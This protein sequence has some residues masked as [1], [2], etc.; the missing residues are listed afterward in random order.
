MRRGLRIGVALWV[1]WLAGTAAAAETPSSGGPDPNGVVARVNQVE[2]TYGEFKSRLESFERERGPIPRERYGD[3]LRGMIQEEVLLQAAVADGLD[4]EAATRQ[5]LEQARRQVL[6]EELIRRKVLAQVTVT[7]E[8]AR[9]MYEDN[10]PLF[11]TET[12]ATSHILVKTQAEAEAVLQEL[13][14]GKEFA[15]LAQTRSQDTGS[16]EKGGDLGPLRRGQTVPEFE[17]EAFRLKE[18]ELSAVLKTEYGYHVL[19]GGAHATVVQPFDEVKDRIRQTLLQEKQRK[20]FTALLAELEK[21]AAAE[22]F[23]DRLR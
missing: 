5:R 21:R 16:A 4:K 9:K 15:E 23:E 17:E 8:E 20:T 12:V 11:S 1:A 18:G 7:D 13:Q 3:V 2:I 19:K 22:V 10:K 6:I 14:A